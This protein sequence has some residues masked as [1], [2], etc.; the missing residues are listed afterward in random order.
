VAACGDGGSGSSGTT[1][2]TFASAKFFGKSDLGQIVDGYNKSQ[3]KIKG[4]VP[5]A[6]AAEF[7]H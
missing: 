5:G 2:L 4:D 7:Q 3:S 1:N 6:A